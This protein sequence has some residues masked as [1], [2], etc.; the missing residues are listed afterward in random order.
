MHVDYEDSHDVATEH[1]ALYE[2]QEPKEPLAQRIQQRFKSKADTGEAIGLKRG[3][4]E[5]MLGRK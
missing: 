3:L 5:R 1:K 4:K 2:T